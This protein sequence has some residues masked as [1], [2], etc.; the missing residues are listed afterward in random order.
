MFR[1]EEFGYSFKEAKR[2][3]YECG[4]CKLEKMIESERKKRMEENDVLVTELERDK[5]L[6]KRQKW[7]L[8]SGERR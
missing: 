2:K 7:K 4:I 3:E 6:E 1:E 5:M 8:G